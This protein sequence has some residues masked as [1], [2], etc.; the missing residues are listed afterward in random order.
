MQSSR[1]R[2]KEEFM[3]KMSII[4]RVHMNLLDMFSAISSGK[5]DQDV[6]APM[7]PQSFEIET[8]I[9]SGDK[10]DVDEDF[11][12]YVV[13]SI[14]FVGDSC[15]GILFPVLWNLCQYLGGTLIDMGYLVAMF[16]LGRLLVTAPLGYFCDGYGHKIPLLIASTVLLGGSLLWANSYLATS[17]I[18]LYSAQFL[19]GCGSG[20]LGDDFSAH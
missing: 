8:I 16:S 17:L 20:S 7:I 15:R 5:A 11:S 14:V 6:S 18:L 9:Q 12:F 19:M 10:H 2:E 4:S 1:L 3:K 13:G